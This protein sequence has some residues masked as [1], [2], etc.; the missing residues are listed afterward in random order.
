LD[1]HAELEEAIG[2]GA[3]GLRGLGEKA[4]GGAFVKRDADALEMEEAEVDHGI[5]VARSGGGLDF[6]DGAFGRRSWGGGRGFFDGGGGR[7]LWGGRRF[8]IE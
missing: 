6:G 3:A 7:E 5:D 4:R 1:L 2:A 8:L